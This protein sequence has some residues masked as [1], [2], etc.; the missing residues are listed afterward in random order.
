MAVL[1]L[2]EAGQLRGNRYRLAF[3]ASMLA[4]LVRLL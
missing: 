4:L 3:M 1:L 2:L